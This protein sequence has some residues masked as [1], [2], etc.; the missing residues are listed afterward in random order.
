M[1]KI[2]KLGKTDSANFRPIMN[3]S[4][5]LKIFECCLNPFLI[6][7]L[8]LNNRQFGFRKNTSCSSAHIILKETVKSYVAERSNVHCAMV[9]VSKAFDKIN[10]SILIDKLH[11]SGLPKHIIGIIAYMMNNSYANIFVNNIATDLWKIGNGTRQG[12]L[13]SPLIFSYYINGIIDDVS[14]MA[15]G[16]ELGGIKTNIICYADDICLLAPSNQALQSILNLVHAKLKNIG[17]SINIEKCKYI[18]FKK[19]KS[20]NI[21]S[22]VTLEGETI[23]RVSEYRYLGIIL[24]EDNSINKDI[25]RATESFL[26]QFNSMFYKFYNMSNEVLKFLFRTYT[27]SFYGVELWYDSLENRQ[28]HKIAVPYHA[29]VKRVA[30]LNLWD[31]N[32]EACLRV[33][34]PIFKHMLAKRTICLFH[35]II[36]SLSPCLMGFKYYFRYD[37][38]IYKNLQE[39][40]HRKYDVPIFIENPLCT[41]ISRINYVERNEPRR[42]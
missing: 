39:F 24:S 28:I 41:M 15:S 10:H 20:I 23:E 1:L 4:N 6:R 18:V 21:N 17:L 19:H 11:K 3:S 22:T 26:K 7:H 12:G 40:F 2:K 37:S 5:F 9:D 25:N 31:S 42:R 16:C 14:Q 33:N 27:T 38:F 32:H 35:S 30:M 29:A 34:V 36:K 13:I 8:K